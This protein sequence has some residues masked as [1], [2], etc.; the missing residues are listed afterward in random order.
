MTETAWG[1]RRKSGPTREPSA[2]RHGFWVPAGVSALLAIGVLVSG[3]LGPIDVVRDHGSPRVESART[4]A[5]DAINLLEESRVRAAPAYLAKAEAL[6]QRSLGL[7]PED[8]L[9]AVVGM[10][11]LANSRHDFA[12]SVRWARKAIALNSHSAPAYGLLG[13]ALYELGRPRASERA[14]QKMIDLRPNLASYTR[15]AYAL[16]ARGETADAISALEHALATVEP[17]GQ[18]AAWVRHQ[19]GDVYLAA[20]DLDGAM[21]QNRIGMRLAPGYV[22]P[23]VGVAEAEMARGHINRAVA[24]METATE[25][26]P[27]LEYLITLGDLYVAAGRPEDARLQFIRTDAKIRVYRRHGVLSD[28]DFILFYADNGLRLEETLREARAMFARRHTG[29][30]A[31]A[32]GWT[33]H[34]TGRDRQA[35]P[36]TRKALRWPIKDATFQFH[37]G[38]I[39]SRTGRPA[40]AARLLHAA[41][42]AKGQL[43]PRQRLEAHHE[44]SLIASSLA[45][46]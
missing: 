37:A 1:V 22:P 13:D 20:G 9:E 3:A 35:W 21:S 10:A 16:Q 14:Y 6:L 26:M 46:G 23:T 31:D 33:L 19:L 42:E 5:T 8:N 44:L 45:S 17:V 11:S 29:P 25:R 34:A 32:L 15:A 27:A 39:A 36:Y 24:I 12:A 40:R 30:V 38:V 4:H 43:S 7:Q 41:L 2:R 18:R 28:V